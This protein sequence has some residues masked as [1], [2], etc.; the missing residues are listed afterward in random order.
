MANN[1][2]GLSI[3]GLKKSF[4]TRDRDFSLSIDELF[5]PNRGFY[6]FLGESGSGKSTLLNIL[7]LILTPDEGKVSYSGEEVD[8]SNSKQC[9]K[10]RRDVVS[11]VF[12]DFNLIEEMTVKDNLSFLGKEDDEILAALEKCSIAHLI[13]LPVRDLSGGERQRV[14]IARAILKDSRYLL[15]DEPT[16]NLDKDNSESIFTLLKEMSK[17][18]CIIMVTHD[19]IRAKK[20]SNLIYRLDEGRIIAKEGEEKEAEE[21]KAT[22]KTNGKLSAK[23]YLKY[24]RS[25]I[26]RKKMRFIVSLVL[27]MMSFALIIVAMDMLFYDH[28]QA[29]KNGLAS[30]P[31]DY[32]SLGVDFNDGN[33]STQVNW[34]PDLYH[35]LVEDYGEAY[36]THY[37]RMLELSIEG[38]SQSVDIN[39]MFSSQDKKRVVTDMIYDLAGEKKTITV[40]SSLPFRYL[41]ST[42]STYTIDLSN[43]EVVETGYDENILNSFISGTSL[44]NGQDYSSMMYFKYAYVIVPF[45]DYISDFDLLLVSGGD[46]FASL[47]TSSVSSYVNQY[48]MYIEDPT[49]S[50]SEISIPSTMAQNWGKGVNDVLEYVNIRDKKDAFAYREGSNYINLYGYSPT[51]TI[52]E[53]YESETSSNYIKVSSEF[54]SYIKSEALYCRCNDL[55]VPIDSPD[56]AYEM[57]DAGY[58]F[59]ASFLEQPY[60]LKNGLLALGGVIL[61]VAIFLYLIVLGTLLNFSMSTIDYNAKNI[62]VFSSL[63]FTRGRMATLFSAQF[64]LLDLLSFVAGSI[65]GAIALVITNN[66]T[67][68]FGEI[69]YWIIS[70]THWPFI[71]SI[72]IGLLSAG[73]IFLFSLI[74]IFHK[75][76]IKV[77]KGQ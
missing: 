39:V 19:E 63:G 29:L 71:V 33:Y 46:P 21:D 37:V 12:Q 68:S 45:S 40:A 57:T 77:M 1:E 50:G 35:E 18:Q 15:V 38:A 3:K 72:A 20:Y 69:N 9:C 6:A 65:L 28:R 48:G 66:I 44:P 64:L 62:A 16:G 5:I 11:F 61:G 41:D 14:A 26:S 51:V 75:D 4:H 27:M 17:S 7:G 10:M 49:L 54:F 25:I 76:I 22:T 59:T 32:V 58:V 30:S 53:L 23:F 55:V 31:D 34:G 52:K 13:N 73:L 43:Y 60:G 70:I 36:S 47:I 8:Y 67:M 24:S 74:R 56:V 42:S 2:L